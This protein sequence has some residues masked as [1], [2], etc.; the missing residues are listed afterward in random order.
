LNPTASHKGS[1]SAEHGVGLMKLHALHYS[2]SK[3]SIVLMKRIKK[4][5]DER[6]IMNPGKVL[7]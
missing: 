7:D 6:G 4:L 5:F 2:K 1:I 3:E